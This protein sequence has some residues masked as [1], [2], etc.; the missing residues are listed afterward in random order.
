MIKGRDKN[1]EFQIGRTFRDF[2]LLKEKLSLRWP[3]CFIAPMP[4]KTIGS[5][6]V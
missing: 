6:A 2:A 3:G 5:N 1:G 4:T